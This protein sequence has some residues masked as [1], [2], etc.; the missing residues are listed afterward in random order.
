MKS[1]GI[2]IFGLGWKFGGR[3]GIFRIGGWSKVI[4]GDLGLG[5]V[6]VRRVF[7]GVCYDEGC[8]LCLV[9]SF[10]SIFGLLTNDCKPILFWNSSISSILTV[11]K[12]I[13]LSSNTF[14]G[15]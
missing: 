9:G 7:I 8:G 4:G 5:V 10:S 12:I 15:C 3:V 1:I 14:I 6:R 11:H 13:S 2:L